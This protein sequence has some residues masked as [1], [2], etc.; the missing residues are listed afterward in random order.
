[1]KE[2]KW[3]SINEKFNYEKCCVMYKC[4]HGYYPDWYFKFSTVGENTANVT[5][6]MNKLYVPRAVTDS[7]A[8]AT[9]VLGPK[10]WNTLPPSVDNSGSLYSFKS[11]LCKMLLDDT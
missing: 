2:L 9:R 10:L 7:G 8:R 6:Q 3:M 1:M 11:K 5:R 4:V